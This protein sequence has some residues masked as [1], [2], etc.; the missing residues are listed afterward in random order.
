[1]KGKDQGEAGRTELGPAHQF[2]SCDILKLKCKALRDGLAVKSIDCSFRGLRLASQCPYGCSQPS[3]TQVLGDL[4]PSSGLCE[5]YMHVVQR[6]AGKWNN[7]T[8][9]KKPYK[10]LKYS[11]PLPPDRG[12]FPRH[13]HSQRMPGYV[14]MVSNPIHIVGFFLSIHVYL[15]Q[16]LIYKLGK[17]RDEQQ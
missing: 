12:C 4:T 9:T 6:Q 8:H 5:P 11:N 16:N 14:S 13:P 17:L 15:W 7:H 1:M 3:V 2:C 10:K